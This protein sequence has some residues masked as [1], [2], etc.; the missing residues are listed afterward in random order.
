MFI[1]RI[2]ISEMN[3]SKT[4]IFKV[5]YVENELAENIFYRVILLKHKAEL[6]D[7]T[8]IRISE[9]NMPLSYEPYFFLV[10]PQTLEDAK[11]FTYKIIVVKNKPLK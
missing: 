1:P 3:I 8:A 9:S 7:I 10:N 11:D 2:K 5:H 4:T 6:L